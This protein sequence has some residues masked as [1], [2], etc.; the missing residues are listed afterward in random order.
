LAGTA[1]LFVR[2]GG[3]VRHNSAESV[4]AEDVAIEI[5]GLLLELVAEKADTHW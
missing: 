3:R 5:V 4:E 1:T 2:Y